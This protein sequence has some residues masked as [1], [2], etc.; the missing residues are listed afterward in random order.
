MG[1]FLITAGVLMVIAGVLI[2]YWGRIPFLGK[3]PGDITVN[4]P[5]FKFYFPLMTSIVLSLLLSLLLFLFNK[6]RH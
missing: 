6:F 1:K 3:L 5:N 4:K 2:H